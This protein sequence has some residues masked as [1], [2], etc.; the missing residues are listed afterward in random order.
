[1][2]AFTT[3]TRHEGERLLRRESPVSRSPIEMMLDGLVWKAVKVPPDFID[4]GVPYA[5]HEGVL[6]IMGHTFRCFRLSTGEA[7]IHGDDLAA[8]L[9]GLTCGD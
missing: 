9:Q 1:M 4:D 7:V 5:T 3:D 8:F 2:D 6:D